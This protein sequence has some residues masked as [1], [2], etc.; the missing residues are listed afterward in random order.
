MA[1]GGNGNQ[2]TIRRGRSKQL[3][4]EPTPVAMGLAEVGHAGAD[5]GMG[6][7]VGRIV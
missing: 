2:R 6:G 1:F 7:T 5:S 4:T 3:T